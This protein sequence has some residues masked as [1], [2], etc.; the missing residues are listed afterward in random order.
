MLDCPDYIKRGLLAGLYATF[1]MTVLMVMPS[2][3]KISG[4]ETPLPLV[5]VST[6]FG[7]SGGGNILLTIFCH[8]VYGSLWGLAFSGILRNKGTASGLLFSLAPWI[9]L[10]LVFFPLINRSFF[11]SAIKP[12]I[13]AVTLL[14]HL[15][16]GGALGYFNK[17]LLIGYPVL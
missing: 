8:L 15:M 12:G 14:M 10:I 1:I 6:I 16:Y 4:M 9:I 13:A 5:I 7:T 2:I 3:M 17:K 11:Y